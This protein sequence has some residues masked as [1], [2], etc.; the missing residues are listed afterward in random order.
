MAQGFAQLLAP[1]ELTVIVNVGDDDTIYGAYVSADLDTVLYTLAGIQG[2]H[3]WGITDD[4]FHV[5]GHLADIGVD[6]SFRLGDRDLAN[7]LA[8]TAALDDGVA[9]S[10]VTLRSA[11]ALGVATRLLPASD[12]RV[13]TRVQTDTGT[14]LSFQDYFVRGRHEDHVAAVAFEGAETARPSPGAIEAIADADLV[15][16]APS[17][18]PL[19]IWPILAVPGIRIAIEAK[20]R[21]LAVSPLFGGK[22]LKGPAVEVMSGLGLEP[23]TGGILTAYKD[24]ITD[25]VIDEGDA[26]DT[27]RFADGPV[28]IHTADT[29]IA[30]IAAS[31]RLAGELQAIAAVTEA[32]PAGGT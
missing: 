14:W 25:L 18:P 15:V 9:L 19:S 10:K 26:P 16:I 12:D 8:R 22:A 1:N 31:T 28:R 3:G 32:A 2:P 23:N 29:R 5:M 21:V 20:E 7:C 24:L 6:I 30:D 13:R 4:T 17:N 11:V 27:D